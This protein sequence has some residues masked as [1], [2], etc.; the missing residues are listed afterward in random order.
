MTNIDEFDRQLIEYLQ[1]NGTLTNTELARRM[2]VS[3]AKIRRCRARLLQEDV[4][5]VVAVVDPYKLGFDVIAIVGVR[6]N[7]GCLDEAEKALA[8][9]PEVRFLG[10][11]LGTYDIML[12]AWFRSPQELV[13]FATVTLANVQGIYRT[14]SFQ[15]MRLAKYMYDWGKPVGARQGIATDSAT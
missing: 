2:G 14:E 1:V 7:K 3:E 10:I 11:T 15:L 4:I 13:H 12:E 6:V 9:M 5:R 8:E